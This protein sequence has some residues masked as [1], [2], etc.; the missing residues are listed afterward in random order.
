MTA[1]GLRA[2]KV[3][4]TRTQI[5]EAASKLFMAQGYDA[6]T[7]EEVAEAADIHKRTL[8]RYF[9]SKCH[10]VLHP[11][12]SA[13]DEFKE[14]VASRGPRKIVDVWQEHVTT[15]SRKIEATGRARNVRLIA[16]S[17]P[18]LGAALLAIQAEYQAIISVELCKDLGRD[19]D[20]DV[21][22]KVAAAALVGANYA[23][24]AMILRQEAYHDLEVAELEVIRLV[25]DGLLSGDLAR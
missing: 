14:D 2:R 12:Y 5:V 15:H 6:T 17:E 22:S 16:A 24:G 3:A 13:L 11:R 19:P 4:R 9:P 23:V 8:L 25:R 10:L 18:A 20:T 1:V 7:L 21:L